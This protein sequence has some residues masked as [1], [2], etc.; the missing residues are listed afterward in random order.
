MAVFGSVIRLHCAAMATTCAQLL[1][2]LVLLALLLPALLACNAGSMPVHKEA[3]Q[4]LPRAEALTS[5]PQPS[6][7]EAPAS[8]AAASS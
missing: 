8:C 3:Q 4:L 5:S 2:Y 6:A 1:T 7:P